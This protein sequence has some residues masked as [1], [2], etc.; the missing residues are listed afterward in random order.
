MCEEAWRNPVLTLAYCV[1]AV[2]GSSGLGP[3]T[4]HFW[5]PFLWALLTVDFVC[6]FVVHPEHRLAETEVWENPCSCIV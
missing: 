4:S 2:F 6:V 5:L 1:E 3:W